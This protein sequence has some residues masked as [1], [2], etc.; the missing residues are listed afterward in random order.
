MEKKVLS[1][2]S[3]ILLVFSLAA[4]SNTSSGQIKD[5]A[6]EAASGTESE[7]MNETEISDMFEEDAIFI[8][9]TRAATTLN[10]YEGASGWSLTSHGISESIYMQ[11]EDGE[12]Y[13][14]FISDIEQ[15][16]DHN[17]SLILNE[18]VYFSDGS[19]V[20]AQA[21][22]DALNG[23]IENNEL[24]AVSATG[25]MICTPTGDFTLNLETENVTHILQCNLCEYQNIMYK[26]LGNGEFAFTGPYMVKSFEAG[27]KLEMTP[28]PYYPDAE[29]RSDVTIVVFGDA[30]AM[31]LAFEAGE[32]D[33]AV[34][35]TSD[36]VEML[37]GE[38]LKTETFDAGYQ[39]FIY[40]NLESELLQDKE[41]RR[42]INLAINREDMTAAMKGGRVASGMFANYYSFAG[43]CTTEYNL[44]EA[45]QILEDAGWTL[46]TDGIREKDGQTLEL[47]FITYA[48]RPDLPILMQLA[49]SQ[50]EELGISFSAEIVDNITDECAAGNY[51]LCF[52]AQHTAPSGDPAY[53]LRMAFFPTEGGNNYTRYDSEEF[54]DVVNQMND[55]P[56]GEER[57]ALARRA[58]EILYE[59]LPVIYVVDPQWHI[60]VSDRLDGYK[61]YCGDYYVVNSQLGIE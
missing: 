18:D 17:W 44:D 26:D 23:L 40:C 35:I 1:I 53:F 30:S 5:Q 55:L 56:L 49:V 20:D 38:G 43:E 58:Q 60:A 48:S 50:L 24:C 28:N 42:A 25:K 37:E 15:T 59:D 11:N 46:N 2:V 29:K 12:L 21:F 61:P 14:R 6:S 45:K 33:M 39:Y 57:D 3:A 16:D 51:D 4:C 10:P 34:T 47:R 13:S 31:K 54:Q 41:V 27:V 9:Q 52:Y 36:V 7:S 19:I 8:G 32:I 22:S